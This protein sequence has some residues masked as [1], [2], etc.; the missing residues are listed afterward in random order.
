MLS[1]LIA[2]TSEPVASPGSSSTAPSATDVVGPP[3]IGGIPAPVP[4]R[5]VPT[6]VS[7]AVPMPTD[8][9]DQRREW[10]LGEQVAVTATP[11]GVLLVVFTTL[12]DPA[13]DDTRLAVTRF[14]PL[15]QAWSTP[16][17]LFRGPQVRPLT[18]ASIAAT[19][20]PVSGRV[21]VAWE[22]QVRSGAS[23]GAEL[24]W[25]DDGGASWERTTLDRPANLPRLAVS[26]GTVYVAFRDLAGMVLA[27]SATPGA[28]ET[29]TFTSIPENDRRRPTAQPPTVRVEAG[30][31]VVSF[32][33]V[34]TDG[35]ER[36]LTTWTAHPG[37]G[38]STI[39]FPTQAGLVAELFAA[40]D[41]GTGTRL[42]AVL[43]H[44]SG[45]GPADDLPCA[46]TIVD[47]GPLGNPPRCPFGDGPMAPG[48]TADL[49]LLPGLL[50]GAGTA[51]STSSTARP[52]GTGGTDVSDSP[53]STDT[54][55]ATGPTDPT[56][57]DPG[58]FIPGDAS[59]T[60]ATTAITTDGGPLVAIV[61]T[62]YTTVRDASTPA[63]RPLPPGIYLWR[64]RP[65][66]L[67]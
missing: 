13:T 2:C 45:G 21:A 15:L 22:R 54:T 46:V 63:G 36:W 8:L 16:T 1:G 6:G 64:G 51:G 35:P 49:R 11:D 30:K 29:W 58:S 62:I 39:D 28:G 66:E 56:S 32:E 31:P 59:N 3:G 12:L 40:I 60:T 9:I 61:T 47:D 7:L 48:P 14:D 19:A 38:A 52:G 4:S 20:D 55:A 26:D 43:A 18:G 67:P 53:S 17:E 57:S 10:W 23:T 44:G 37:E 25:S 5:P 41:D 34:S 27:E 24:A 50:A 33:T 42:H 65:G